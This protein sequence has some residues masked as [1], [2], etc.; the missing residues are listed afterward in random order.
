[1][2]ETSRDGNVVKLIYVDLVSNKTSW[3]STN[4]KYGSEMVALLEQLNRLQIR[5]ADAPLF[6]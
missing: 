4:A 1:V 3:F 5:P 2:W 6:L